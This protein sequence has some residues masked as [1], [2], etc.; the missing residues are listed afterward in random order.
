[1]SI[2]GPQVFLKI[3]NLFFYEEETALLT[4]GLLSKNLGKNLRE[5]DSTMNFFPQKYKD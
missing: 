5:S 1:M 4:E 3:S 2:I